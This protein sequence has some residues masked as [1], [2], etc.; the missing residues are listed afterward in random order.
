MTETN[1]SNKKYG[2]YDIIP[3]RIQT[4]KNLLNGTKLSSMVNFDICD[5]EYVENK[6]NDNIKDTI[7]KQFCKF[8]KEIHDLGGFIKFIKSGAYGHTFKGTTY[9]KD[10]K[11]ELYNYAIKVVAYPVRGY[12]NVDDINRPENA[13]IMMLRLLANFVVNNQTP[14]I[15]LPIAT[16]NTSISNFIKV[17]RA[18]CV[19]KQKYE[20]FVKR[21]DES[22]FHDEVSVLISEWANGGD[23]LEYIKSNY[24]LMKRV[25]W[26]VI[27]FQIIS[28]MAV[29]QNKYPAFRHNDLKANNI[30]VQ[31]IDTIVGNR[32]FLI[33]DLKLDDN[34]LYFK[35]INT[36][37]QIKLW[38]FDFA[39]IPEKINNI[40]VSSGL[41]KNSNIKPERNKYYD[42]HYFFNTLTKKGFFPEFWTAPE[43]PQQIRNFVRDIVPEIYSR[44]DKNVTERGRLLLNIE[45]T[46][47]KDILLTHSLFNCFRRHKDRI[48]KNI[49][50]GSTHSDSLVI[51]TSHIS[52][53]HSKE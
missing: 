43:V 47:P 22:E 1:I 5:T 14:H 37:I 28:V 44:N 9:D 45:Y 2:N 35:V 49:H 26:I 12:G 50:N 53:K 11:I 4:I 17:T 24:K 13:E 25:D 46:T 10:G 34:D 36:G 15:V 52:T 30:L 6:K 38:D 19:G 40:K 3:E 32:N 18:E 48:P 20:Q 16:F 39:C 41:F 7:G 23:L 42:I 29:I 31:K 27:F 33:Y 51:K 21:Y 8:D